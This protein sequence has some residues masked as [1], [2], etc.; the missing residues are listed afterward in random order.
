VDVT[1]NARFRQGLTFQMG[2]STGREIQDTC[3][4]ITRI[5][6]PDPR[7]CRD[8]DP[9]ETTL[10]GLASY[11]IPKVD[12]LVSATMRS[13]PPLARTASW[14]VPNSVVRALLGRLPRGSALTGN[15][16]VALLDNEHRLFADNRRTQIDMRFAKIFRFGPTRTDIGIDL[17]NLLNTN[18]AT[19]Y[20][21][22]YQYSDRNTAMGG[23]WNEPTAVYTPRFARV[24]LTVNF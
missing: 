19:A 7:N 8:V 2:T 24:N 13:Q 23:S 15:T 11:T 22:T 21:N 1:L 17:G 3:A 6:S 4:T 10:R 20:E 14:P 16:T 9:F 5:D 18:Y 12:V